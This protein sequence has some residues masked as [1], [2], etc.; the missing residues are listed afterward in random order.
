MNKSNMTDKEVWQ[1]VN[2]WYTKG[3]YAGILQ[4]ENGKD[5]EEICEG[6]IY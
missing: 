4:D 3:M 2:M 1:I 6:H 5:L